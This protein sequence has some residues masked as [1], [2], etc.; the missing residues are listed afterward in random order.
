MK[1][2]TTAAMRNIDQSQL[3][4]F[5]RPSVDDVVGDAQNGGMRLLIFNMSLAARGVHA[6][7]SRI[8]AG[9]EAWRVR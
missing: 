3:G 5:G 8:L 1:S 7:P 2:S 6:A 4:D 9:A